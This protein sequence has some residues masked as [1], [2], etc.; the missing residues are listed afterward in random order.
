MEIELR[1]EQIQNYCR[2][3]SQQICREESIEAVVPDVMPDVQQIMDT[4]AQVYLRGKETEDGR[5]SVSAF[6]EGLA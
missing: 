2:L 1:K 4:D 6:L 5:L 3:Y